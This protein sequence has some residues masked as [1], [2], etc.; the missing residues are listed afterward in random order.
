[1]NRL[2]SAA[3]VATIVLLA[4][5]AASG[6]ESQE[7]LAASFL[8][9]V[10]ASDD[11][12]SS[13]SARPAATADASIP[14]GQ[15]VGDPPEPPNFDVGDWVTTTVE[16]LKMREDAGT[17]G[18]LLGM[19]HPGFEGTVIEGPVEAD[20]YEWVHLAWPG[21]PPGG[22]CATGPDEDGFL[23][24]C[25]ANGWVATADALGNP[26]V[27]RVDPDCPAS[28]PTT[29][30]EFI[31]L[32]PGQRLACVGD[33]TLS[34]VAYLAPNPQGR[35]CYPGYDSSPEWLGPCP[36][37]FLQG[38]E[39]S[40]DATEQ[41][42][43]VNVHRDLGACDFGGFGPATC[44]FAQYIGEWVRITGQLDHAAAASCTIEPWE[45]TTVGPS[46]AMAV[47]QCRERFVV[48]GVEPASAP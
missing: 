36:V 45:G 13:P 2:A 41:E 37:V 24:F 22:G 34:L 5:C 12:R 31:E 16:F 29:V 46:Q 39:S 32:A 19:L 3:M 14:A 4:G 8:P 9:D 35:G 18:A 30:A 48:T 23:S 43:A 10:T 21:L 6:A 40:V 27:E 17:D 25:G 47:Y 44:P 28:A 38:I 20:G 11:V 42:I 15:R 1:V 33:E 7:A 26:W